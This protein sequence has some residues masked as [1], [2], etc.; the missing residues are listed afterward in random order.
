M[1]QPIDYGMEQELPPNMPAYYP[2]A[3]PYGQ[4]TLVAQ[5]DP[6]KLLDDM[7]HQLRNEVPTMDGKGG[8]K[9]QGNPLANNNGISSILSCV[10]GIISQNTTLSYLEAEEIQNQM[11]QLADVLSDKLALNYKAY[12]IDVTDVD[13]I[14]WTIILFPTFN[15]LKRA[16]KKNEKNWLNKTVFEQ[17]QSRSSPQQENVGGNKGWNMP[18]FGMGGR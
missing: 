17:I 6:S 3:N 7:E 12:G 15:C 11:E 13:T 2:Q 18:K 1:E 10:R 14:F 9:S 4:A 16:W 5:T 8:Y